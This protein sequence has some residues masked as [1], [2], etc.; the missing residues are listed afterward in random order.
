MTL[1]PFS[2]L[3]LWLT[4]FTTVPRCQLITICTYEKE[5]LL[6]KVLHQQGCHV[7]QPSRFGRA[8]TQA[9]KQ[10]QRHNQIAV[11]K[12]FT[13]MPNHI[14]LFVLYK[15]FH[16]R[17]PEWFISRIKE[18]LS[19]YGEK[20]G[21]PRERLWETDVEVQMVYTDTARYA[22]TESLREYA[23]HWQ[24]DPFHIEKVRKGREK[25]KGPQHGKSR[26]KSGHY[27]E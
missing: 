6:G 5:D 18:F 17:L 24:Y 12:E 7:W 15:K 13:V 9:L 21:S 8:V 10:M 19:Q 20:D 14:H 3:P 4:P 25:E 1:K 27:D 2:P 23:H 16:P 26:T 22:V 11:I